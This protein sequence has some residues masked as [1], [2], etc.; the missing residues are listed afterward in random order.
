MVD[1]VGISH[2]CLPGL[3]SALFF[4]QFDCLIKNKG[5][6]LKIKSD[7]KIKGAC[8]ESKLAIIYGPLIVH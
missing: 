8:F 6:M 7:Q 5:S 2:I 3:M 4:P 1:F